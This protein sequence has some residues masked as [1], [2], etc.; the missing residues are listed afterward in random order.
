MRQ[1]LFTPTYNRADTL[2]RLYDS[3]KQQT[4]K[5]F[6]WLIIDDGSSDNTKQVVDLFIQEGIIDITYIRK[7]NGGKHTAQRMAYEI[8]TTVYITEVDSDD[9]LVPTAIEDFENAGMEIEKCNKNIAKVSM[10]T[11]SFDG[12]IRGYGN[13]RMP[14][15]VPY[16][17]A[18]W[19]EYV[20]KQNNHREYLS[21]ISVEKFKDCVDYSFFDI[22]NGK[23]MKFLGES[24]L[25]SLIGKKY[26]TRILNK[27][28]L[29]VYLDATNSILRG[30]QNYFN[31][32]ANS[33][34][35]VDLN[36]R[37]F[38]WNPRYFIGHEKHMCD[39]AV[40]AGVSLSEMI[41][42]IKNKRHKFFMSIFYIPFYFTAKNKE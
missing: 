16:I 11:T 31:N 34:Y 3:I 8:A 42:Y 28:G 30:E 40:K 13:Y 26:S 2:P 21:S 14:V 23:P 39:S 36:I 9:A 7:E 5:D 19:Q 25:W 38:W 4:F 29:I 6:K 1:T 35:F 18:T 24:I 10:F 32:M 22:S 20:L 41:G 12:Q 33:I 27:K 15:G 37:Y 17:D